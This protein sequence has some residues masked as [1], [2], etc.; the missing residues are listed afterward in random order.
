[1][2]T[3]EE[4]IRSLLL[5]LYSIMY[6]CSSSIF[7]YDID[8]AITRLKFEKERDIFVGKNETKAKVLELARRKNDNRWSLNLLV[9]GDKIG[10]ALKRDGENTDKIFMLTHVFVLNPN[11]W[12]MT[13]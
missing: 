11:G 9:S 13:C 5:Q 8:Y 4:K 6:G 2:R 10:L 12:D 3:M 7:E 1:M